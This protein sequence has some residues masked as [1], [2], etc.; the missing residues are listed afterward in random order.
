MYLIRRAGTTKN[1]TPVFVKRRS[2][3]Y[4]SDPAQ[5]FEAKEKNGRRVLG[6]A[7]K[8]IYL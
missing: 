1:R 5:T 4:F 6:T 2:T 3:R 7:K 8:Y